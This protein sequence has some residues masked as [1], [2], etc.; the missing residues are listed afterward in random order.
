MKG[1]GLKAQGLGLTCALTLA[2]LAS[3]VQPASLAQDA[4]PF[5]IEPLTSPAGDDS[6]AP[7]LATE[8]RKSVV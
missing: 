4:A 1:L 2:V 3:V 5:R 8:D 6:L 7:N